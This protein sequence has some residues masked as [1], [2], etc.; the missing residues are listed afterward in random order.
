MF[1]PR[2]S[3]LR[4]FAPLMYTMVSL[5]AASVGWCESA[6]WTSRHCLLVGIWEGE[7]ARA[8]SCRERSALTHRHALLAQLLELAVSAL[9]VVAPLSLEQG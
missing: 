7:S 2:Y 5:G 4:C 8:S 6:I 1:T 3:R 9:R